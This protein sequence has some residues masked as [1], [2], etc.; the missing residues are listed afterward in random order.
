MGVDN[1]ARQVKSLRIEVNEG[2]R[3]W[4]YRSPMMA[5]SLPD[6]IWSLE[7]LLGHVPVPINNP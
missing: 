1:L 7:E 3:C 5:A 2:H 4:Q 6:H